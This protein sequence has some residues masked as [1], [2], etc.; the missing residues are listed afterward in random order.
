MTKHITT[1][2]ILLCSFSSVHASEVT[3]E[4]SKAWADRDEA[5]LSPN[6]QQA[7]IESQGRVGGAA[8]AS[9]LD[10]HSKPD[11]SPYTL[12][13]ELDSSGKVV[14]TWLHGGSALAKCFNQE[15]SKATLFAPPKTPFY[16][17]FE[18]DWM[19]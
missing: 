19:P 10:G 12:V 2:A 18:M 6:Q 8:H 9:C 3:Y 13:M 14:R 1:A 5:S 11:L 17:S 4:Q 15:M 16:T 7:L